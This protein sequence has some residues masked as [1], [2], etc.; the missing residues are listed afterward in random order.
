MSNDA[1]V[2]KIGQCSRCRGKKII[3][4]ESMRELHP[5]Y[6]RYLCRECYEER[7]FCDICNEE[8]TLSSYESHLT[9]THSNEEMAT[10]LI[11]Y[12]LLPYGNY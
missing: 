4:Y 5:D 3:F 2:G 7:C 9:E 10:R 1:E 11:E 8:T 12:K 6:I